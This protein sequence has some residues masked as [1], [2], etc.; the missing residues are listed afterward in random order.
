MT[1]ACRM[2]PAASSVAKN[3][4]GDAVPRD[5]AAYEAKKAAERAARAEERKKE[6]EEKKKKAADKPETPGGNWR[7]NAA[8]VQPR[9][10]GGGGGDRGARSGGAGRGGG[11]DGDRER[12]PP[13]ERAAA[14]AETK[15]VSSAP[16]AKAPKAPA[17]PE[18]K[19]PA[20]VLHAFS[21]WCLHC[22]SCLPAPTLC[23]PRACA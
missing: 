12:G 3:P 6:Q 10:R 19:K 18:A 7:D 11:R 8:P 15:A 17:P 2:Q 1:L 23:S 13:R 5:E 4:F 21:S 22:Q 14:D 16:P 20:K 9:G